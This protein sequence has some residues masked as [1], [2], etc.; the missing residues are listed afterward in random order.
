MRDSSRAGAD[1]VLPS[2]P[3]PRWRRWRIPNPWRRRPGHDWRGQRRRISTEGPD[4]MRNRRIAG[5]KIQHD[6]RTP[7]AHDV[8]GC[9]RRDG[10]R[11]I[12]IRGAWRQRPNGWNANAQRRAGVVPCLKQ[13]RVQ[14]KFLG[15]WIP[16]TS[17]PASSR[18]LRRAGSRKPSDEFV[19]VARMPPSARRIEMLPD[20]PLVRL[21]SKR[22]RLEPADIFPE[23]GFLRS[24]FAPSGVL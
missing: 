22:E 10:V 24:T 4:R 9:H 3:V 8:I 19:G 11:G 17:R 13:R 2:P 14:W 15:G 7:D 23:F 1:R 12:H 6:G 21:R 20:D 5:T 16:E 18:R